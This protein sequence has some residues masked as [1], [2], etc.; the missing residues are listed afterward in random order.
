MCPYREISL[1]F[2]CAS[3]L[4][5]ILYLSIID[6][7]DIILEILKLRLKK[8]NFS[9]KIENDLKSFKIILPVFI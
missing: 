2:C 4:Q 3:I 7:E 1:I 5:M 9:A 6:K 8:T